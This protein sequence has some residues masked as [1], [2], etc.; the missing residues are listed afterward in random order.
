MHPPLNMHNPKFIFAFT[1]C[2]P[3]NFNMFPSTLAHSLGWGW[4]FS[5]IWPCT[6]LSTWPMSWPH[7]YFSTCDGAQPLPHGQGL[8]L[9][10][11]FQHVMVHDHLGMIMVSNSHI[12]SENKFRPSSRGGGGELNFQ[13]FS[14][15]NGKY[16][17]YRMKVLKW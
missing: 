6:T 11:I 2:F 16:L 3:T 13:K 17:K 4:L 9:T 1:W 8:D 10:Y 15:K 7:L 5:N 12:F 14:Q